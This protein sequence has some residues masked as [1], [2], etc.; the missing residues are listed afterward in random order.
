MGGIESQSLE[1]QPL[2]AAHPPL[3]IL[4]MLTECK[5]PHKGMKGALVG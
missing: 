5:G 3:L 2:D 1:V 4:A